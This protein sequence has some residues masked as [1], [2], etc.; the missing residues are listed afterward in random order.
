MLSA[1]LL[2][3][4]YWWDT[5][6]AQPQCM[7]QTALWEMLLQEPC[8]QAVQSFKKPHFELGI[9]SYSEPVQLV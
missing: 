4:P 6:D 2:N 5:E 3:L 9:E 8:S 7:G 1:P